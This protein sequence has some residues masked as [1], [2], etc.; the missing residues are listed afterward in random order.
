M[1]QGAASVHSGRNGAV[2]RRL[3][4]GIFCCPAASLPGPGTV[5]TTAMMTPEAVRSERFF[6]MLDFSSDYATGPAP[7]GPGTALRCAVIG[8]RGLSRMAKAFLPAPFPPR[9]TRGQDQPPR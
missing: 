8:E 9:G 2:P 7:A 5:T 3:F 6:A 4:A 1:M